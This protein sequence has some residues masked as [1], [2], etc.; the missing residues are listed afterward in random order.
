MRYSRS[1]ESGLPESTTGL[2]AG[3]L[4]APA[5]RAEPVLAV[6]ILTHEDGVR[7]AGGL[8]F[9]RAFGSAVRLRAGYGARGGEKLALE[10]RVGATIDWRRTIAVTGGVMTADTGERSWE[11]VMGASLRVS[12]Y[13]LGVLR[14]LL[15]N[16]FGAA[17]SFRLRFGF[18]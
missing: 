4:F 8:E 11:P 6:S 1:D 13:E 5:I 3:F 10:H 18:Q 12:R 7:Y 17:Y 16:D 14:E 9:G 15:A 2:G